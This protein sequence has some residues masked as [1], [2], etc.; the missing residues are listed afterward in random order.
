MDTD[1]FE[2][3]LA[4]GLITRFDS[5]FLQDI[6]SSMKQVQ[7]IVFDDPRNQHAVLDCKRALNSMTPGEENFALLIENLIQP[8]HPAYY[9]SMIIETLSAY[10]EFCAGMP[11]ADFGNRLYLSE[12]VNKAAD[13][14]RSDNIEPTKTD[15]VEVP[16]GSERSLDYL[17]QAPPQIAQLYIK[18]ALEE[19][20][21]RI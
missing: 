4:R 5:D 20:T 13:F 18:R 17:M 16:V 9:K 7:Y 1:W 12:V 11:H 3:R 15:K 10:T 21:K 14:Y 6:W 2:W 19:L 8:L